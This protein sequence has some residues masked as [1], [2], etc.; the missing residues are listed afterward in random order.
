MLYPAFCSSRF[1]GENFKDIKWLSS[2]LYP[3]L[4]H[5]NSDSIKSEVGMNKNIA[6]VQDMKMENDGQSETV[7]GQSGGA[8]CS[9]FP[10]QCMLTLCPK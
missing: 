2:G 10:I 5:H 8:E 4:Q 6:A 3:Q 1:R 7:F 9:F